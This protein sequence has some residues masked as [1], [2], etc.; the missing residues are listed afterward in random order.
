M[1]ASS[2]VHKWHSQRRRRLKE[3]PRMPERG[4]QA[5]KRGPTN[6]HSPQKSC[7]ITPWSVKP[8]WISS[9][10]APAGSSS[11]CCRSGFVRLGCAANAYPSTKMP[12]LAHWSHESLTRGLSLSDV[13]RLDGDRVVLE[14]EDGAAV[15]SFKPARTRLA[16]GR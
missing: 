12:G 1:A 11:M 13:L 7:L 4:P 2:F 16:L 15:T 5:P 8:S 14:Q 10:T 6:Q 9:M 3:L